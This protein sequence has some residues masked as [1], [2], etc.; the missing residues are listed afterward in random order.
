MS[1]DG[2][3]LPDVVLDKGNNEITVKLKD[4]ENTFRLVFDQPVNLELNTDSYT[5]L[6]GN[7]KIPAGGKANFTQSQYYFLQSK[8]DKIKKPSSDFTAQLKLNEK[9]WNNY[10]QQYFSHTSRLDEKKQNLL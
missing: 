1:F 4:K 5:A 8:E 7:I 9:R 10:L 6:M 2:K 3:L